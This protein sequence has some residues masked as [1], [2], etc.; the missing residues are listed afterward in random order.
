MCCY[1]EGCGLSLLIY[2]DFDLER[3][4]DRDLDFEPLFA[5]LLLRS[6]S[7]ERDRERERERERERSLERLRLSLQRICIT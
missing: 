3:L 6:R 1:T 4:L 2:L 7:R 5:L